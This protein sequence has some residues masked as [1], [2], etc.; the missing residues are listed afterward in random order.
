MAAAW[1]LVLAVMGLGLA[2]ARAVPTTTRKGCNTGMF[3]SLLPGR[4]AL[5]KGLGLHLPPVPQDPG[6]EAPAGVGAPHTL[7]ARLVLTLKG[8]GSRDY[9]IPGPHPGV[10]PSHDTPTTVSS[11][12]VPQQAA[13]PRASSRTGC[14]SSRRPQ[15]RSLK[16]ASRPA[17][18]NLFH[19]LTRDVNC[20]TRRDVCI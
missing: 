4:L 3:K 12:P 10:A 7:G 8:P 16:T 14:H 1:T 20:V 6:S 17:A 19:L 18:F 15:R 5:A 11:R 9:L 2:R 13:G